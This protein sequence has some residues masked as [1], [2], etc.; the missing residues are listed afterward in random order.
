MSCQQGGGVFHRPHPHQSAPARR[1]QL[2][3]PP[4]ARERTL[5]GV[6]PPTTR[7]PPLMEPEE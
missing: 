7:P 1:L 6:C 4:Q 5:A 2:V 3:A